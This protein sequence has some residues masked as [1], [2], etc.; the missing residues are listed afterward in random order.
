M[1]EEKKGDKKSLDIEDLDTRPRDVDEA[2]ADQVTGGLY[3]KTYE[4]TK[5]TDTTTTDEYD[6]YAAKRSYDPYA[7]KTKY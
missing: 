7:T 5:T 1:A 4:K 6:P 2:A 3:Y